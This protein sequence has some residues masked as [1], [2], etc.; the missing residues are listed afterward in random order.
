MPCSM[1][2]LILLVLLLAE[3]GARI[4]LAADA[5][6]QSWCETTEA[7]CS[8][9]V[10]EAARSCATRAATGGVDPFTQ[11]RQDSAMLCGWFGNA[12]CSGRWSGDDCRTR[13]RRRFDLCLSAYESNTAAEY[14]ACTEGR[15]NA[16]ALCRTELED[17][18]ARCERNDEG[19]P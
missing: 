12:R 9:A 19:N 5:D 11:R 1:M 13:M 3:P 15:R 7:E 4:A 8:Q 14:L 16:L 2:R 10:R 18:S 17:C 6:C